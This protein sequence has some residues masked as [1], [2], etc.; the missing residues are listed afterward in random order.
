MNEDT[1]RSYLNGLM[2]MASSMS[3]SIGPSYIIVDCYKKEHLEQLK[4]DYH[5]NKLNLSTLSFKEKIEEWFFEDKKAIESILFWSNKKIK[6]ERNIYELEK[7]EFEKMEKYTPFYIID[8]AFI[9]ETDKYLILYV[10]G[11]NE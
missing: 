8:D 7:I 11:N 4:K 5:I 6:E 3:K 2:N 1:I 9:L 10:L